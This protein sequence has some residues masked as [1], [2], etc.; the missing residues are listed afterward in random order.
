MIKD[1]VLTLLWDCADRDLSGAELAA[2]LRVSRGAVWKAVEQLRQEGYLIES[3]PRRGYRLLSKSD[4][5]NQQGIAR[6]LR[7]PEL[8]LR[9]T[10]CIGSTN[11]ALKELA[12]RG[13][14]E[15]LALVAGQQTEGRGRMG[16][17]FY[18]P[19]GSGVYLSLLLRPKL[20][21]AE[22]TRIT[23]CAAVA[24]AE[25][26]EELS[27]RPIGIKWVND[28][29]LDGKKICGIL[30]EASVDCESGSMNY[31]IVGLGVNAIA[32]EGGFPPELR[33]VAG[34]LFTERR[35]P[36]LRC[37]IA[38]GILD[39]LWALCAGLPDADPFEAYRARSL[40]LGAD[41]EL[42]RPGQEPV[43]ATVLSLERD[44]GLQVKLPDGSIC[45]VQSGE[46]RILPR[47]GTW[48]NPP[49]QV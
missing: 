16:R 29:L 18:S 30:T 38:A 40:V 33:E 1:Q 8:R 20:A 42:L 24:A 36:E 21:A 49:L 46:V 37:Q 12:N 7:S 47:K 25:V 39:R 31:V 15:G 22:G 28:L 6:R 14:P 32:P 48:Q 13:E 44:Y 41:V 3:A 43:P 17:S 9:V 35:L 4:V 2:R 19:A 5:L 26:L 23:A 34:A 27:G 45:K 11:T 10:D